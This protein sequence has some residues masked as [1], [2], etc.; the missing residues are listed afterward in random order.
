VALPLAQGL[1]LGDV[2]AD[3]TIDPEDLDGAARLLARLARDATGNGPAG[4]LA[5]LPA[6]LQTINAFLARLQQAAPT[7]DTV[8]A[9]VAVQE[10]L[11]GPALEE[12]A[13]GER[14]HLRSAVAEELDSGDN[15]TALEQALTQRPGGAAASHAAKLAGE[16]ELGELLPAVLRHCE[17]L[18]EDA[19]AIRAA[20]HLGA[21][22]AAD[23]LLALWDRLDPGGDDAG[24]RDKRTLGPGLA[25]TMARA[26]LVGGAGMAART[27]ALRVIH[28]AQTDPE[29]DVR[30]AAV[31]ACL[32]L[33]PNMLDELA[34]A[35][36]VE[37]LG[38]PAP[39]VA[40]AAAGA[41]GP[42]QLTAAR[43]RLASLAAGHPEEMVRQ[44]AKRS[45]DA[46][47]AA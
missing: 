27:G 4:N 9:L 16:L 25:A 47:S 1:P 33:S 46:L 36:L 26:A 10:F 29:P 41:C 42:L 12:E 17:A 18:P 13:S 14:S 22:D 24:P 40:A 8:D 23:T 7:V 2:L 43:D 31:V 21:D 34:R 11:A 44:A 20:W 15:T 3:P 39:V 6:P 30:S 5:H 38:D 37:L 35:N 28:R 32:D 19:G 45:L